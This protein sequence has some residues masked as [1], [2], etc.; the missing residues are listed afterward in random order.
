T[1]T[2]N[3]PNSTLSLHD[4]L[5]IYFLHQILGPAVGFGNRQRRIARV[6]ID[7]RHVELHFRLIINQIK[8]RKSVDMNDRGDGEIQL[9]PIGPRSEEHTSELQS[10]YDIVCRLL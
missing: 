2:P 6:P 5:P 9:L 1:P 8:L 3:P 7:R 4:A 10:P